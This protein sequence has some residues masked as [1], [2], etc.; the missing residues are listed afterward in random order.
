M[1]KLIVGLG[2]IGR[3]YKNSRHNI[4]FDVVDC[5]AEKLNTKFSIRH[6]FFDATKINIDN[7]LVVVIAKSTTYMNLSGLAVKAL[8]QEYDFDI[9]QLLIVVDD[10]NLPLGKIRIRKSGS[11][12]GHNGLSSIIEELETENFP[13]LRLGI[14]PL[15]EN[16]E[17]RDFVLG[18]FK[19]SEKEEVKKIINVGMEAT[20]YA[21]EHDIDSVMTK[22]NIVNP[23]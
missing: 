6:N 22:Y 17:V 18:Q 4:G 2:N 16:I 10:F 20:I 7:H 15:P 5:V 23:A 9:S 12:G 1:T 8:L 21:K 13:R 11:D 3:K 14:G 19:E